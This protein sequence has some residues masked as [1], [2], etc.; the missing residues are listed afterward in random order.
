MLLVRG[1]QQQQRR[2]ER[3]AGDHDR[4]GGVDSSARRVRDM[5]RVDASA[6]RVGAEPR[7]IGAGQQRHIV[8]SRQHR[9]DADHLRV[10]LA[11]ERQGSRRRRCSACTRW[12]A[13][14]SRLP[15]GRAGCR[16]AGG[17]GLRPMPSACRTVRRSSARALP[18]QRDRAWRSAA[19]W[20]PRRARHGR[21]TAPPPH[22]NRARTRHT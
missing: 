17:K 4:V 12:S 11:V 14:R 20:D 7:D 21:G 5:H 2:R 16:A 1:A 22:R 8:V 3:A 18:G 9:I 10:G 15:S 6:G 19:R 13:W